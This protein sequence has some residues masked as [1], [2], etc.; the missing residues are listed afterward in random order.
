LWFR[1][2][3]VQIPSIAQFSRPL[4]HIFQELLLGLVQGLTEFFPVSSSAHLRFTRYLLGLSEGPNWIY[5]DLSCHAGTWLALVLF[6]RREIWDTLTDI[7]KIAL[8]TIALI[9]LIP[10]YFLLKS[11]RAPQYTGYFLLITAMLL[12][13]ASKK[14]TICQEKKWTSVLFIGM[15]QGAALLP[16][17]SR[18]GATIAAGRFC[19]WSFCDAA[20][21]SFLLAIPTILGGEILE[22]YKLIKGGPIEIPMK[23]CAV[24]LI[25]SFIVG[26]FAVRFVFWAYERQ[27]VRP[28][29]WYCLGFGFLM[30]WIING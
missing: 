27:I 9:P 28:F 14:Q 18:S 21:F 8:Y 17:I 16:G 26:L 22:S 30:I 19:N 2:S 13:L 1:M 6:L 3:R 24:G 29:A 11:I 7:R 12:F 4:L 20:K 23:S 25:S 5:F 15:M 10:A